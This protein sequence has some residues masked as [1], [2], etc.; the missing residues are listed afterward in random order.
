MDQV[1][2]PPV[3]DWVHEH[4]IF[5][6]SYLTFPTQ[7]HPPKP[8]KIENPCWLLLILLYMFQHTDLIEMNF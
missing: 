5:F 8:F 7:S 2:R 1:H 4:L 3:M 6:V